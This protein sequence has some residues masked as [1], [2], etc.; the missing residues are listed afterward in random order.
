MNLLFLTSALIATF[1]LIGHSTIG[2]K[3]FFLP[4][5][6]ADFEAVP[7]R[8]MEFVWHMSTVAL[9]LP[10][11]VLLYAANY[12][13]RISNGLIGFIALLYGLWAVVHFIVT[14]TSGIPGGLLKLFQW[15]LFAAVAITAGLGIS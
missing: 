5:V 10:P 2:R 11:I 15:I 7:K 6:A 1:I 8:V 14:A 3:Q 12:P 4:M 9:A 13:D